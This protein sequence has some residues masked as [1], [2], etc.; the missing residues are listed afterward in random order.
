MKPIC[1][2]F[3]DTMVAVVFV[4]TILAYGGIAT[5]SDVMIYPSK[6]QSQTK[7]AQDQA[8]CYNWAKQKSGFDPMATPT[9][10]TPPP[11]QGIAAAVSQCQL[12]GE[13]HLS[14]CG[15]RYQG[16]QQN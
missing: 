3:P 16:Y 9:A 8:E 10:T 11:E 4:V 1:K 7:Q 14:H 2:Q 15:K 13:N 12:R 5:A 6:G